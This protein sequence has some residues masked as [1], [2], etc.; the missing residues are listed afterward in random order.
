[1]IFKVKTRLITNYN[2]CFFE[3]NNYINKRKEELV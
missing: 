3:H 1:M 2:F